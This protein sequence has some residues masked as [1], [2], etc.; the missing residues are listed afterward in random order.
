MAYLALRIK[1]NSLLFGHILQET[2]PQAGPSQEPRSRPLTAAQTPETSVK[3][4]P[5]I[6]A[7]PLPSPV[8][9]PKSPSFAP[10]PP[11]GDFDPFKPFMGSGRALEARAGSQ[12]Q[13]STSGNHMDLD[14]AAGGDDDIQ[15][16][17]G[18]LF[19]DVSSR[20]AVEVLSKLLGNIAANPGIEKFR[21]VRL[22]NPKIA[23][24]VGKASGGVQL[25][26]AVGFEVREEEDVEGKTEKWAVLG[27]TSTEVLE[28]VKV[29][30]GLLEQGLASQPIHIPPGSLVKKPEVLEQERLR[31]EQERA[32]QAKEP[33]PVEPVDRQVKLL[34]SKVF[35]SGA[36]EFPDIEPLFSSEIRDP[37][38][39]QNVF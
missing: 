31:A 27:S 34:T 17:V 35:L 28:G 15:I 1:A 11:P 6:P 5:H 16:A 18:L 29:T 25:L 37:G 14:A 12:E 13:S 20:P 2:T 32:Q 24:T 7:S 10:D 8:R 33:E 30:L 22:G 4:P 26:Q 3:P 36:A 19:S 21:R 39:V 9:H 38:L 23:D